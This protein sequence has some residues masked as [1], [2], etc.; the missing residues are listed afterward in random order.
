[1]LNRGILLR[2]SYGYY[3]VYILTYISIK[4]R[5]GLPEITIGEFVFYHSEKANL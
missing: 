3:V 1:M 4:F 2:K 5:A